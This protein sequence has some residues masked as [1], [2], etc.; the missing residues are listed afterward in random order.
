MKQWSTKWRSWGWDFYRGRSPRRRRGRSPHQGNTCIYIGKIVF[1]NWILC[2]TYRFQNRGQWRHSP[3]CPFDRR[4]AQAYF[5]DNVT[6]R[7]NE[8][9]RWPRFLDLLWIFFVWLTPPVSQC[10]ICTL[11][12][13][14]LTLHHHFQHI[15]CL[16]RISSLKI[17]T[18]RQHAT[19]A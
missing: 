8:T 18:W 10:M 9:H 17:T 7:Q 14:I 13:V 15:S 12:H 19:S 5:F 11:L 3:H 1:F 2:Y 16:V 6:W 4:E